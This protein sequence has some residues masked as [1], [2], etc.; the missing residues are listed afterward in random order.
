MLKNEWNEE[1]VVELIR[2]SFREIISPEAR[3][4]IDDGAWLPKCAASSTR[5]ISCDAFQEKTDFLLQIAP[6][7]AAGCRAIMQNLSDLA[8]MGAKP[9]GFVWS[10]EI[11]MRWLANDGELLRRF[12]NGAAKASLGTQL[13]FYGG[14]LSFSSDRFG[15]T[16]TILGDVDGTPHSRQG[17]Q[18][19]DHIYVSRKLGLSSYGLD[20]ILRLRSKRKAMTEA[21]F[22][23][24][25]TSL[26]DDERKA[27]WAHLSPAAEIEL[28]STML[29]KVTACMDI[30]DGLARDLH[31]LCK[32]SKV[33]A[34]LNS[35]EA[36]F[37]EALPHEKAASYAI[38]GGE[39]F[40]LLFTASPDTKIAASCIRIGTISAKEGIVYQTTGGKVSN[41][42]PLGYDH[43]TSRT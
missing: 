29:G 26:N 33:G 8:A 2:E 36:V 24:F 39:D 1:S 6:V 5:V 7:E 40:A 35:L 15:C 42:E 31:R 11:P 30:S 37:H 19:G 23:Q 18:S 28:A 13:Q 32:A 27:V 16:I 17:A 20:I 3:G 10:L 9:V 4:L 43:F 14:D 21:N 25:V 34:Q 22:T 41:L 12:C 38:Y